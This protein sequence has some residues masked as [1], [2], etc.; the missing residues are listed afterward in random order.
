MRLVVEYLLQVMKMKPAF[1]RDMT[2]ALKGRIA[3]RSR[4]TANSVSILLL[5]R[6]ALADGNLDED[7]VYRELKLNH[8]Y[9]LAMEADDYQG[10]LWKLYET[11]IG[12]SLTETKKS[13]VVHAFARAN[14]AT[15]E[16]KAFFAMALKRLEEA[17]V[18]SVI[19]NTCAC[20]DRYDC[21]SRTALPAA[22]RALLLAV[23]VWPERKAEV[24]GNVER[25][26]VATFPKGLKYWAEV[27][28]LFN[29]WRRARALYCVIRTIVHLRRSKIIIQTT[30]AKSGPR[31]VLTLPVLPAF[32]VHLVPLPR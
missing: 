2:A 14:V 23:D 24:V 8:E 28:A 20:V 29:P 18:K 4:Y 7:A 16:E 31:Y 19:G 30:L 13:F 22:R 25:E 21:H 32:H 5:D 11:W 26:I 12:D 27:T 3:K 1:Q 15:P 9:F 17:D 10:E 6:L